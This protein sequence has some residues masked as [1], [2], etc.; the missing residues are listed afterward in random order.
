MLVVVLRS[1]FLWLEWQHGYFLPMPSVQLFCSSPRY[2]GWQT[3]EMSQVPDSDSSWVTWPGSAA[4]RRWSKTRQDESQKDSRLVFPVGDRG[5]GRNIGDR[6]VD[7]CYWL[8]DITVFFLSRNVRDVFFSRCFISRWNVRAVTNCF[9]WLDR[10][11]WDIS[12]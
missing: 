7:F 11:E 10:S 6:F 3:G 5:Y 1:V 4:N 2:N 12:Q 9:A 8:L